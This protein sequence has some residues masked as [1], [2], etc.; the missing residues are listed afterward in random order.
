MPIS[1]KTQK[2][3]WGRAANRCA[4]C[5]KELVMDATDTDDESLVGEAC[6]IVAQSTAGPRGISPLTVEQRDKY[7]NL[8]LL[9]NVHH[10][11]ID[12]QFNAYPVSKLEE[13]KAQ[14][15]SWVRT[16]LDFDSQKQKEEEV[17]AGYIE[18]WARRLDLDGWKSWASWVMCHGLPALDH[19]QKVA[20]EDIGQWLLS[21]AWPARYPELVAA[22]ANF[23]LVAQDFCLV[24]NK[25]A[26][27]HGDMWRTKKFYQQGSDW[28]EESER[29]LLKRFD[30][31]VGLVQDLMAE[32]T[33]AV[34][35]VCDEVRRRLLPG[36]RI[37][38]GLVLLEGGPYSSFEF[39]TYRLEYSSAERAGTLYLGIAE[40]KTARFSRA[41]HF[42][43]EGDEV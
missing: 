33:R 21:R 7:T 36:F 35:Y 34:N 27:H 10:K 43:H 8:I 28:S 6:H 4:I 32:L 17:W 40:F 20:L 39:K 41:L 23:R 18:E 24:F 1:P 29:K 11:Q 25:H 12:D 16:Q 22:F 30:G 5:R 13:I 37:A 31:H 26:E 38:E 42:G 2:T 19:D 14:H 3:L 9:C 15:E